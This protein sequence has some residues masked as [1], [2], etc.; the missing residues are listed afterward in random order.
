[1]AKHGPLRI[2]VA[3]DSFKGALSA[4]DVCDAMRLGIARAVP[5]AEIIAVPMA[6]GGEGTV[7]SLTDATRGRLVARRVCGPLG[8][9]VDAA[10]GIL[11]DGETAV[12]EMAA[13][14]GLPL[15]P[16][17][18]RNPLLATT[19]GTGE[20]IRAA[21]NEGARKLI[22]GIGGSATTDGGAGMAQALGV[23]FLGAGGQVLAR[24][25]GGGA[26]KDVERIDVSGLDPRLAGT[27]TVVACDVDNPLCG[28]RGAA[29][30]YGPQKGATPEQVEALD[31]NLAHFADVI[32]RDLGKNIRGLPGAGAAGGLG[33]GLVAFLDAVLRPGVDIV[34][35]VTR[36]REHLK[37][38]D[39]VITG[40]GQI[41]AQTLRGKTPIGV[42]KT[43]KEFGLPVIAIGGSIADDADVITGSEI[44]VVVGIADRP[45]S[46]EEAMAPSTA[47]VLVT[48]T[49]QR[50][51]KLIET[52]RAMTVREHEP[53]PGN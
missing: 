31:R 35:E 9:E 16:P 13:A 45:L 18:Q 26:L 24:G 17:S 39:L 37:S 53:P 46:L 14:S 23:R 47:K 30:V 44:D 32:E 6:D 5:D 11:G 8:D 1:V 29:Y 7:Q 27:E 42:A 36:L 22:I 50:V 34:T 40:E 49:A 25:L 28:P 33:A 3:P 48:R 10:F 2:V 51:A 15:V 43:A 20:L 12:I 4:R 21:L 19:Y 41:D 52:G 38:A